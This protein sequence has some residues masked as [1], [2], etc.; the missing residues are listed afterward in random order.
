LIDWNQI[1]FPYLDEDTPLIDAVIQR[2]KTEGVR[3]TMCDGEVLYRDGEFTRVDRKDTLK[4][5]HDGLQK[6]FTEAELERR[7][8]SKAIL[9]FIR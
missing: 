6:P 3:L 5:L 4:R 1:A 2:A 8:L 7:G 9:P